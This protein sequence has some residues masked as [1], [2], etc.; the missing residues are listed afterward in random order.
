[1]HI[2]WRY[3]Q[4]LIVTIFNYFTFQE[5]SLCG[6]LINNEQQF[7]ACVSHLKN[8]RLVRFCGIP[9]LNDKTLEEVNTMIDV[10][11]WLKGMTKKQ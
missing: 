2:I 8:L 11:R 3:L 10:A 4:H 6:V 7:V 9:V 5:L 1:M